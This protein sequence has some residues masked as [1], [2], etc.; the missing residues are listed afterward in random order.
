MKIKRP[1]GLGRM[2]GGGRIKSVSAKTPKIAVP[3]ARA[4]APVS[5]GAA[6]GARGGRRRKP[7]ILG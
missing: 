2:G 5:L 1:K 7:G 4:L 3:K 6:P